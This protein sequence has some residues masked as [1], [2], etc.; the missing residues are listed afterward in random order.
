[1]LIDR[2]LGRQTLRVLFLIAL[3]LIGVLIAGCGSEDEEFPS[4][5]TTVAPPSTTAPSTEGET[6]QSPLESP[7]PTPVQAIPWDAQPTPG[8]ANLKGR[9]VLTSSTVLV[10]E[11]LLAKA[12]STDVADVELLELDI[13]IA[14]RAYIDRTTGE[15]LFVHIEP[16]RYGVIAW[17]PMNS[18]PLVNQETGESVFIDLTADEVKD[19]GTLSIP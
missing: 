13:D 18:T 7:L 11:L 9:I 3:L 1:M 6:M 19:I 10:A 14:P 4:P 15:F 12:V 8:K 5:T 2:Y 16:G 17:E